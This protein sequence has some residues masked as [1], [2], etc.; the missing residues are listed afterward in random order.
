M[1]CPLRGQSITPYGG[2][3]FLS[4][5]SAKPLK[6]AIDLKLRFKCIAIHLDI[7]TSPKAMLEG[8]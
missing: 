7:E 6:K 3:A 8:D 4:F 2:N 1:H 5:A